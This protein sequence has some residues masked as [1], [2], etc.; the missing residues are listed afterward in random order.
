M[1]VS[2]I[3]NKT[4]Q[5]GNGT[6]KAFNFSFPIFNT[7]DLEVYLID[8]TTTPETSVLQ[9]TGFTTTISTTTEG[10]TVTFVTAPTSNQ[11]VFI[12]RVM[13]YTQ[14]TK[15]STNTNFPE[16]NLEDTYDKSRMIDIQLNEE[17]D[18][19]L[20][21][22]QFY[23]GS[24]DFT[25]PNPEAGKVLGW[26][27]TGLIMANYS[28]SD[29]STILTT[30]Y[31]Q[32][33]VQSANALAARN[34][35]E[36]G[37]TDDVEFND[38]TCSQITATTYVG[39]PDA[40]VSTKGI[41]LLDKY[42][43]YDLIPS[44]NSGNPDEKVDITGGKCLAQDEATIL[45]YDGGIADLTTHITPAADTTYHLFV[46]KKTGSGVV[47]DF[48]T[49][50]TPTAGSG[51][52]NLP[53]LD[54]TKYRLIMSY[55]TDGSGDLLAHSGYNWGD[56]GILIKYDTR[57][58]D[59]NTM[60]SSYVTKTFTVPSG[61]EKFPWFY[62]VQPCDASGGQLY[63]KPNA[64]EMIIQDTGSSASVVQMTKHIMTI[65][66]TSDQMDMKETDNQACDSYTYGYL[67]YRIQY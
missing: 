11:D 15:I 44:S 47:S 22:N 62:F 20:Q 63:A 27:A 10:G 6:T 65:P 54:G 23:D 50:L 3:T 16:K 14:A 9:T 61:I 30:S 46:Y 34:T 51:D 48:S 55:K 40:T 24:A 39:L 2:N 37:T 53:D 45:E 29:L 58:L 43:I 12:K 31:G 26:D 59:S 13:S 60:T 64:V 67:L 32:T 35:L 56:K 5:H 42:W 52:A 28:G 66:L 7:T 49:S 4:R 57:V 8:T 36:L 33:L 21:I 1:T 17:N 19:T 38:F 41:S 18:R 25:I